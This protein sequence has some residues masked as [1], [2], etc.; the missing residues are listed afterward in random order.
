MKKVAGLKVPGL[1]VL[2]VTLL[3]L[4]SSAQTNFTLLKSFA[5]S[6]GSSPECTLITGNDG[7]LYGTTRTGGSSNLGTVFK[8]NLDGSGF[9]TL[10]N[11]LGMDGNDPESGLLQGSDGTL[12]GTTYAGGTS[13]RGTIFRLNPDGSGYSVLHNFDGSAAKWP[14]ASLI[15]GSDGWL[16]G[17][18]AGGGS[19]LRGTVF[20]LHTNGSSYVVIHTFL[21]EPNDGSEPHS[22]L[23]EDSD[24]VLY[25]VT[26]LGGPVS[27]GTIYKLNKDGSGHTIL[28]VFD[29]VAEGYSPYAGLLAASD[30][31][32]YGANLYGGTNGG[33]SLFKMH[34]DGSGFATIHHFVNDYT[35]PHEPRGKLIEGSDGCLYGTCSSGGIVSSGAIFKLNK[36]GSG[37]T[38]L[39]RFTG[40]GG[41]GSYPRG[42]LTR[43]SNDAFYG[44]TTSGGVRLLGCIY[45]LSTDP[46]RPRVVGIS[47]FAKSNLVQFAGTS[48]IS[49][50]VQRST[51]LNSWSVLSNITFPVNGLSAFI[52]TNPPPSKAYYRLRQN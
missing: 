42:G 12:Y 17:T 52:D 45:A 50:D 36:D 15:Q 46:L 29:F 47:L 43:A 3:V 35:E 51:N 6:N 14:S 9:A 4:P 26:A 41:D 31:A 32:L 23:W 30:G 39:R 20:K 34:K 25:G 1:A 48:G 44:T 33:G 28:H 7:A 16:Y 11:F 24:G 37:L 27:A 5:G 13:N 49:Y 18:T 10:K 22:E 8:I 38:F 21:G 40:T 19:A 2:T